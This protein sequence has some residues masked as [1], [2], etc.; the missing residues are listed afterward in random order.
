MTPWPASPRTSSP[1]LR[2]ISPLPGFPWACRWRWR[3]GA[4]PRRGSTGWRRWPGGPRRTREKP[5]ARRRLYL[6]MAR[7]GRFAEITPDH[8]LPL[9]IS[10][11]RRADA[12]LV[13]TIMDMAEETGPEVFILQETALLEREDYRPLLPQIRCPT[14]VIVG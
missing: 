4:R 10:P 5:R 14:L 9:L 11:V 6:E 13:R 1:P 2:R 12:A 3:S 8:L 7:S